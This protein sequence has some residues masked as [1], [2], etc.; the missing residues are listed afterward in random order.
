MTALFAQTD[1]P[2]VIDYLSLDVEGAETMI[3]SAFPFD[4]HTIKV[5]TVERPTPELKRLLQRHGYV[6]LGDLGNFGESL[7]A[8]A[9]LEGGVAR[10]T[11]MLEEFNSIYEHIRTGNSHEVSALDLAKR[12]A[13]HPRWVEGATCSVSEGHINKLIHWKFAPGPAPSQPRAAGPS[14]TPRVLPV[15]IRS[16]RHCQVSKVWVGC[17][18]SLQMPTRRCTVSGILLLPRT[19]GSSLY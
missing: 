4:S 2:K 15:D 5:M 11:A 6:Q 7:W 16:G 3:M 8:H 9:S 14:P 12:T 1:I 17:L 13:L 19:V 10:A 18:S